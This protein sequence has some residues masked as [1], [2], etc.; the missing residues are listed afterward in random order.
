MMICAEA[1]IKK[2]VFWIENKSKYPE[3]DSAKCWT[4]VWYRDP[5][6]LI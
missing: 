3:S 4:G 6:S 1:K 5:G 2:N